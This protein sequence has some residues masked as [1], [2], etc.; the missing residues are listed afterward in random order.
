MGM[1]T[2]DYLFLK[3]KIK[4]GRNNNKVKQNNFKRLIIKLK[5]TYNKSSS[6]ILK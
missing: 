2:V 1:F 4:K 3:K 6:E 5:D